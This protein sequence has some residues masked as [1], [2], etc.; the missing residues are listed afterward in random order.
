MRWDAKWRPALHQKKIEE[1]NSCASHEKTEIIWLDRNASHHHR[2]HQQCRR[3]LNFCNRHCPRQLISRA[4]WHFPQNFCSC[5]ALSSVDPILFWISF[6]VCVTFSVDFI[7]NLLM[8]AYMHFVYWNTEIRSEKN[9]KLTDEEASTCLTSHAFSSTEAH[10]L[11]VPP[12]N[13][14]DV[15]FFVWAK[16]FPRKNTW[17]KLVS[18]LICVMS[19]RCEEIHGNFLFCLTEYV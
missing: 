7:V 4:F 8:R 2:N 10:I 11:N 18:V 3:C 19:I 1:N 13:D 6:F 14:F 15:F 17:I 5:V 12:K 9:T 16:Y